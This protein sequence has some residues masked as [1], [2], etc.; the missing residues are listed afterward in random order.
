MEMKFNASTVEKLLYFILL[1]VFVWGVFVTISMTRVANKI[2]RNINSNQESALVARQANADRQNEMKAYIQCVL[3]LSKAYPD[4]DFRALGLEE[5]K[6]YLD[7]C[8]ERTSASE[9]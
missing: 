5:T 3:L 2:D 9:K 8:A 4:V 7:K 1:M 6:V